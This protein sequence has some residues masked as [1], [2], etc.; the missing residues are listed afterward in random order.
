VR[1]EEGGVGGYLEAGA[2]F[3][4]GFCLFEDLDF[5][6]GLGGGYCR[7]EAAEAGA[8]Y[9]YVEVGVGLGLLVGGFGG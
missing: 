1:E 8:D 6:A 4:E 7:C 3:G 9:D 2:Y 5:V